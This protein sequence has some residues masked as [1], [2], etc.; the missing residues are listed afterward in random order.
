[1]VPAAARA[2][3][4]EHGGVR[5]DEVP[6]RARRAGRG[7]RPGRRADR[8]PARPRR[9]LLPLSPDP[10]TRRRA[11]RRRRGRRGDD[12]RDGA[13]GR[14]ALAAR[15]RGHGPRA[16]GVRGGARAALAA[17]A[18]RGSAGA[19]GHPVGAAA[20][21][22]RRDVVVTDNPLV[23]LLILFGSLSLVSFGGGNTVL[24]A[25]HREAVQAQHWL[26]DRQF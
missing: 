19:A 9:D 6:R 7:R 13:Q 21:A 2:E 18:G 10:G 23:G 12:D 14:Y 22:A 24:P 8:D 1:A 3:P 15:P 4:G 16:G 20:S 26:T 25:M 17:R 11:A 5:R